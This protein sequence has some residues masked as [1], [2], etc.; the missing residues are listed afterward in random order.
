MNYQPLVFSLIFYF[1]V[2]TLLG[3]EIKLNWLLETNESPQEV[4][5]VYWN[6]LNRTEKVISKKGVEQGRFTF[7]ADLP[8]I[9]KL[10]ATRNHEIWVVIENVDQQISIHKSSSEFNVHGSPATLELSD[11]E[12][13]RKASFNRLIKVVREAIAVASKANQP[14]EV[15]QL[16]LLEHDHYQIHL[17][18]LMNYTLNE[19]DTS[20]ALYYTALRWIGDQ[21]LPQLQQMISTLNREYPGLLIVEQMAAKA[22]RLEKTALHS[23]APELLIEG[24]SVVDYT[25]NQLTLIEFWGSWCGPC[26]RS[27]PHLVSIYNQFH[28]NGFEVVG[29]AIERKKDRM[30]KAIETDGLNWKNYTDEKMYQS[31]IIDQFNVSSVPTNFLINNKGEIIAKNLHWKAL[32]KTLAELLS[33]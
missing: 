30:L 13:F 19:M 2:G 18:E 11:Y 27:N 33:H 12:N 3:A 24:E 25:A 22:E 14:S 29:F 26:R 16:S 15:E 32:N 17:N 23:T 6:V 31:P 28:P 4:E 7:Q 20:L 10:S 21:Y 1:M 8:G 9:Y 5:L